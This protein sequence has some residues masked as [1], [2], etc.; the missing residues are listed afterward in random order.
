MGNVKSMVR[1]RLTQLLAWQIEES[2]IHLPDD[3]YAQ[4]TK[5]RKIEQASTAPQTTL[6]YNSIFENLERAADSHRPICQDTGVIQFYLRIGTG[7]SYQQ[8]LIECL[9]DSV[10][11]ATQQIPL[12]RNAVNCFEEKNTGDNVGYRVPNVDCELL[13]GADYVEVYTYT[14]G[15]G[16]S[17]PGTAKVL[18]PLEGY[19]GAVDYILDQLVNYGIN[20][21]PP[22]LVGV[23]LAGSVEMAAKLSKKALL[24]EIGTH[25]PLPQARD[26]EQ[27]LEQSINALGFGPGGVGGTASVMA[28]HVE[29]AARHPATLAVGLSTGCWAH[30]RSHSRIDNKLQIE[31]LSRKEAHYGA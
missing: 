28:V 12:R 8:E 15:G 24:R 10:R 18:M 6:F 3:V 29:Q 4:L 25:N 22:L 1:E 27:M 13:P 16:C 17:L 20:A 21:C 9:D 11:L 2:V 14:A 26:F 23:G 5:L 31:L 30:R 19:E 7:F